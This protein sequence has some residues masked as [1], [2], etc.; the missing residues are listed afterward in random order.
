MPSAKSCIFCGRFDGLSKEHIWPQWM[1]AYLPVAEPKA[2]ISEVH[3]GIPKQP[4][5]LQRRSERPGPV[6]TKKVRAV[7]QRCNNTWMSAIEEQAKPVLL[8]FLTSSSSNIDTAEASHL[9]T[10][11]VLKT[12]VGE[13]ASADHLT[14]YED[15]SKLRT[16]GELPWYFR[17]FAAKHRSLTRTAYVRHSAT[18]SRTL[19]G[20]EPPLPRG[21]TRNFQVT[22]LL[23]GPLCLHVSALRVNDVDPALLDPVRPMHRLHPPVGHAVDL[24]STLE[25]GEV[26]LHLNSQVVE[27]LMRHPRVKYGGEI[28]VH[29]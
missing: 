23:V 10:W 27:R 2:H 18:L 26:D 17:V 16:V 1:A 25:L 29:Q 20:P 11:A 8:R 7:C 22:T 21:I 28:P 19:K 15:R 5:V 6:H 14:P 13:H 12:V 3:S 9:S 4:R 24:G